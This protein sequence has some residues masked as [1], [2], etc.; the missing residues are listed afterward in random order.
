MHCF[1]LCES[2]L[3]KSTVRGSLWKFMSLLGKKANKYKMIKKNLKQYITAIF[4]SLRYELKPVGS[5]L[6]ATEEQTD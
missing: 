5:V 3:L 4:K 1:L 6:T 2:H